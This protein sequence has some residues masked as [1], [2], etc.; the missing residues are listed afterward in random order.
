MIILSGVLV[1]L[2]IALLVTGIV[3]GNTGHE[4]LGL[5]GLK[6]IYVSIGVSIVSAL[7]LA[8]GVFL[9]RKELFGTTVAPANAK[10]SAGR[11]TARPVKAKARVGA[12][13]DAPI[14]PAA[15]AT[16]TDVPAETTVYVVPGR[17]RYHLETCRQLAG[18]DKEELT[19][20]EARE[21][22][23]TAC[24]ACLP[25]TALA[26][27]AALTDSEP[28]DD[29][30]A[31][32]PAAADTDT[33]P[34]SAALEP[35]EVTRTD[36]PVT[37]EAP[38]VERPSA[39]ERD[40]LAAGAATTREGGATGQPETDGGDAES[41]IVEPA[42]PTSSDRT[43][44]G[45]T[46]SLVERSRRRS[47]S[48][49]EPVERVESDAAAE[50]TDD[51]VAESEREPAEQANDEK[52]EAA[53]PDTGHPDDEPAKAEDE[54]EVAEPQGDPHGGT[55]ETADAGSATPETAERAGSERES[56]QA[57]ETELADTEARDTEADDAE[58]A[59]SEPEAVEAEP[60][61]SDAHDERGEDDEHHEEPLEDEAAP[62]SAA[63]DITGTEDA[64]GTEDT[65]DTEDVTGT[66]DA[67]DDG[68]DA[69]ASTSS[70]ESSGDTDAEEKAQPGADSGDA[71]ASASATT[72]VRILSGTKRYHRPDCALIEDIADDADDLE[73]LS[74][75]EAR[76]RGCTPCLVCQPDDES[77][78]RP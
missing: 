46:E 76:E 49:F 7:F 52:V 40:A 65:T 50:K 54:I 63:V 44:E 26:A 28:V 34:Q 70:T 30:P 47:R 74:R 6:L 15:S 12:G 39:E 37:R 31:E 78:T 1:V 11:A 16:A 2:A 29:R 10:A 18:R 19:F 73:T 17:K 56:S 68:R 32:T 5:D 4:I 59:G 61:S 66:E 64:T 27:R 60:L 62:E 42:E 51:D 25:D 20:V 43:D 13:E 41:T 67:T 35:V 8:V 9:R 3:T 69:E 21:E 38:T 36:I 22:G 24:T 58:A 48:L 14:V 57:P 23:F 75:E 71:T 45:A 55:A 72:T 77:T 53:S 33:R